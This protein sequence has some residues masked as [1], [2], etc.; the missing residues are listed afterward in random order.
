M[1]RLTPKL[2]LCTTLVA[3]SFAA[4]QDVI[5]LEDIVVFGGLLPTNLETTGATIDV[6]DSEDIQ[7]A[8]LGAAAALDELPGVA[9]SANGGLG[10]SATVRL[11]GLSG[12]YV[13][14]RVDGIDV[15]DPSGPQTAFNFGPLTAWPSSKAHNPRSTARRPSRVSSR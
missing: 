15:T 14:V 10:G 13:G 6:A 9:V 4:A 12:P 11:R 8:G 2:L 3:P 7:R 5:E 1:A